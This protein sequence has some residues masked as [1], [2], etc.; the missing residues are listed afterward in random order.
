MGKMKMISEENNLVFTVDF[1]KLLQTGIKIQHYLFLKLLDNK[2]KAKLFNYYS[3][4]FGPLV[5][6]FD[7]DYLFDKGLLDLL[8]RDKNESTSTN[9]FKNYGLSNMF[10]TKLFSDLFDKP[11]IVDAIEDLKNTYPTKTPAKKRRLQ[12][13]PDKWKPKYLSIIKGKPELHELIIKCIKAEA[14]H[15]R[16]T[17]S[18]EFWPLLTTYINNKRWE[19]YEDEAENIR[20]EVSKDHDI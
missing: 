2:N 20:E 5:R 4:Q 12:S 17:G 19:D 15:R 14:K 16:S 11:I 13:D 3:E 1:D 6:P 10:T 18:E 9:R 8:R 7:V